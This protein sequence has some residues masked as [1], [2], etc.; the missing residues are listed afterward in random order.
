MK[1]LI[2]SIAVAVVFGLVSYLSLKYTFISWENNGLYLDTPDWHAMAS[3]MPHPA[4][5]TIKS[6][7]IQFFMY[8]TLIC[9]LMGLVAGLLYWFASCM[10]RK[11]KPVVQGL[12]LMIFAAF[13]LYVSFN[14]KVVA[15]ERWNKIEYATRQHQWDKVLSVA[16]PERAAKDREMIP[17]ALLALSAKGELEAHL[18]DYPIQGPEDMDFEG[19]VSKRGYFFSSVLYEC[20]GCPNEALHYLFQSACFLP[21]GCSFMTLRQMARFNVELGNREMVEKYC[22]IL[23]TSPTNRKIAETL[24]SRFDDLQEVRPE[25]ENPAKARVV[26]HNP[27]VNLVTLDTSGLQT[28]MATDRFNAYLLIQKKFA[29]EKQ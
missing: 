22:R 12:V 28:L 13:L 3:A 14:G 23:M 11:G 7:C 21:S 24:L 18:W 29:S 2:V 27:I 9:A 15:G 26:T 6:Y 8:P 10:D 16:T 25:P 20:L 1:K 5:F 19:V 17:F 4:L